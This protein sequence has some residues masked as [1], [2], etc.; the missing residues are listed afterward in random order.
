MSTTLDAAL[1]YIRKGWSIMP[2]IRGTKKP[3]KG[4]EWK[5]LQSKGI[6]ENQARSW[7]G[8]RYKDAGIAIITGKV[9]ELVAIDVDVGEKDGGTTDGLP[10]CDLIVRTPSG[11]WHYYYVMPDEGYGMYTG[12]RIK[13]VAGDPNAITGRDVRGEASY[14]IAPPTLGMDGG[15]YE[16]E[17]DD[18]PSPITV[19]QLIACCPRR[20]SVEK[21]GETETYTNGA[22]PP[23]SK[24]FLSDAIKDGFNEGGRNDGLVRVAGH[25]AKIGEMVD[26][27]E[28]LCQQIAKKCT[29]PLPVH[30][31]RGIVRSI[32]KA[33]G[34]KVSLKKLPL[35]EG[36]PEK[37]SGSDKLE[38][39][40]FDDF[41][42]QYGGRGFDWLVPGFIPESTVAFLAGPPGSYKTWIEFDL[43][44]SLATG[45]PFLNR[46]D[47]MPKRKGKV[48]IFQ[49]EDSND[50]IAERISTI[51][52]S[53][54]GVL[55]PKIVDGVLKMPKVPKLN[56][57]MFK[58]RTFR[59]DNPVWVKKLEKTIEE[60]RPLAVFFDPLYSMVSLEDN[61]MQ[62]CQDMQPLKILRDKYGTSFFAVHHTRKSS[63][64]SFERESMHGSQ[65]LN[66]FLETM[67]QLRNVRGRDGSAVLSRRTKASGKRPDMLLNFD[68][69]DGSKE[70]PGEWRYYTSLRELKQSE[71][72]EILD[73]ERKDGNLPT[74]LTEIEPTEQSMIDRV[75]APGGMV[76]DQL[77]TKGDI[78][79]ARELVTKKYILFNQETKTFTVPLTL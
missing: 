25:F 75:S 29:P 4:L 21:E 63:V 33:E 67:L 13:D 22:T 39:Q 51:Y 52:M 71:S 30:E 58:E 16:W 38:L 18:K 50:S 62:A 11:G 8:G 65:F 79:M 2:I 28:V 14:V 37:K 5:P 77:K 20:K 34:L 78:A 12:P 55:Q 44:V 69:F 17:L 42:F 73:P 45:L 26:V 68:I 31:T 72:D 48:L 66:A 41:C 36:E 76:F 74:C 6:D 40:D 64:G 23:T 9:S 3:P 10:P 56:M 7:W 35:L 57:K 43:A 19:E 61:M 1:E 24:T 46:E 15:V 60:E 59:F 54:L 32:Y 53:K 27:C 70:D 47:C 49:Q